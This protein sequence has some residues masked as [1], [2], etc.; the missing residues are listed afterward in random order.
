V[1]EQVKML[2]EFRK[3]I[4]DKDTDTSSNWRILRGRVGGG[5]RQ[6]HEEQNRPISKST[7]IPK[8]PICKGFAETKRTP[9]FVFFF[10]LT[11][12]FHHQDPNWSE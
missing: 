3:E 5:V 6:L 11:S 7:N 8:I 4:A 2:L 10:F 12:Q 9:S 1:S